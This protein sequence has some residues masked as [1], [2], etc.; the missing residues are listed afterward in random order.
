MYLTFRTIVKMHDNIL[1]SLIA[2]GT[3]VLA[4]YRCDHEVSDASEHTSFA[5]PNEGMRRPLLLYGLGQLDK[6]LVIIL[7]IS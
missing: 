4:E 3:T 7:M 6:I 5:W 1:Y 2:R